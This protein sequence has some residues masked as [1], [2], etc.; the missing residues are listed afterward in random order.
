KAFAEHGVRGKPAEIV[1][2][3]LIFED[4][5]AI[6]LLVVLTTISTRGEVSAGALALAALRLL[7][8]LAGLIGVGLLIVP[9]LMR[10]AVRLERAETTLVAAIGVCFASALL[11]LSF[12]YSVALGA[13]LAGSLIAESGTADVVEPLVH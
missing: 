2:G 9:R 6:F 8:F 1:F 11:A 7:A 10:A 12:G 3:I 13:F 5:I 4:L